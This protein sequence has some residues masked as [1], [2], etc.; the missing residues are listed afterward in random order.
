MIKKFALYLQNVCGCVIYADVLESNRNTLEQPERWFTEKL[1]KSSF[2]IIVCSKEPV[3]RGNPASAIQT[4][5]LYDKIVS[6]VVEKRNRS[7]D[8]RIIPVKFSF[9]SDETIPRKLGLNSNCLLLM[10]GMDRLYGRIH[11]VTKQSNDK[12]DF[13]EY[14]LSKEGSD[15]KIALDAA[16]TNTEPRPLE[17]KSN[18]ET[19]AIVKESNIN[20]LKSRS[21]KNFE[22]EF[23]IEDIKRKMEDMNIS[24]SSINTFASDWNEPDRDSDSDAPEHEPL[25]ESRYVDVKKRTEQNGD[26]IEKPIASF[27][28]QRH[29]SEGYPSQRK[30][31]FIEKS[32]IH[33]FGKRTECENT[34]R[35]SFKRQVSL[36]HSGEHQ[37]SSKYRPMLHYNQN[38]VPDSEQIY[39]HNVPSEFYHNNNE[40]DYPFKNQ[41]NPYHLQQLGMNN[42]PYICPRHGSK[43]HGHSPELDKRYMCSINETYSDRIYDEYN[44]NAAY[45]SYPQDH[46]NVYENR[47]NHDLFL[48]T[49]DRY[50]P[51]LEFPAV[52]PQERRNLSREK[53]DVQFDSGY[54]SDRTDNPYRNLTDNSQEF[55]NVDDRIESTKTSII[56]KTSIESDPDSDKRTEQTFQREGEISFAGRYSYPLSLSIKRDFHCDMFIPPEDLES[57]LSEQDGGSSTD[58]MDQLAEINVKNKD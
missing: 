29:F 4:E 20:T 9:H 38:T 18:K 37:I 12:L 3:L 50:L 47:Q 5:S 19:V 8:I 10:E 55:R 23:K 42:T 1:E 48:P 58:I 40:Q 13:K 49:T 31:H 15:L 17:S 46:Y 14:H 32:S 6:K 7:N 53:D 34:Y 35:P 51:R 43:E 26:K 41:R 22:E 39:Q 56:H 16:R 44:P 28:R 2:V 52:D 36:D 27:R 24:V 57:C 54:K 11:L 25:L 30:Q 21:L 33:C 45:H